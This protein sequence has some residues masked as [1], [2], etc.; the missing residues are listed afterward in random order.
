MW[1]KRVRNVNAK[2]GLLWLLFLAL[3]FGFG[4]DLP[5]AKKPAVP[6]A[7]QQVKRACED[8]SGGS[9]VVRGDVAIT[10]VATGKEKAASIVSYLYLPQKTIVNNVYSNLRTTDF[11]ALGQVEQETYDNLSPERALPN[12]GLPLTRTYAYAASAGEGSSG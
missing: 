4:Q 3:P 11:D 8:C 1:N 7:W 12:D 6:A 10:P 2:R 5:Q 9:L